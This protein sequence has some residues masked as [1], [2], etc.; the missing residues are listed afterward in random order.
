MNSQENFNCC[1]VPKLHQVAYKSRLRA[2]SSKNNHCTA[3]L[4]SETA[5]CLLRCRTL[6]FR[7][8]GVEGTEYIVF[9]KAILLQRC[10]KEKKYLV[11]IYKK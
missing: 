6:R 1:G 2:M 5:G 8:G 7:P 11:I 3:T 9:I 10:R 4:A